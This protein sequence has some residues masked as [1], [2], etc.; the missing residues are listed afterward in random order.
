M[1]Y[2]CTKIRT[3]ML[4]DALLHSGIDERVSIEIAK[5]FHSDS[6]W[7]DPKEISRRI[8]MEDGDHIKY[9]DFFKVHGYKIVK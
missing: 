5:D 9:F 6:W 8:R 7:N 3:Q 1:I 2:D 4:V